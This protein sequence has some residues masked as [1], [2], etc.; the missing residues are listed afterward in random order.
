MTSSTNIPSF[1]LLTTEIKFFVAFKYQTEFL[2]F[3]KRKITI[4]HKERNKM[5]KMTG[6]KLQTTP[7]LIG[8]S[9]MFWHQFC[10]IFL[11]LKAE[12]GWERDAEDGKKD[13][14]G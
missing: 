9:F 14:K 13:E 3:V 10:P 2:C 12:N 7:F 1:L 11:V 6:T 8:E 5:I 4:D